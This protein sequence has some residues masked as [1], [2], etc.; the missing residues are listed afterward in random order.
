MTREEAI[1]Q[2]EI[3]KHGERLGGAI[4]VAL[5]MAIS[6]LREQPRWISVD[7]RLPEKSGQ[8]LTYEDWGYGC[9]IDMAYWTDSYRD[10]REVEMYGRAL[11]YRYDS[12]YGD[13]EI[14]C[15]T[16]WMPLPEPP[17][18]ERDGD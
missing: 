3:F 9:S 2:I 7:E 6:A 13:Y 14:R 5:D 10:K 1:K 11:W 12:E 8:Y 15:I 17:K 18:E 4:E 16:H